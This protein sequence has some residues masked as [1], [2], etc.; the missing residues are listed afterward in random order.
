LK[1]NV[2]TSYRYISLINLDIKK[3]SIKNNSFI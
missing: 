3:Y 2:E 1:S